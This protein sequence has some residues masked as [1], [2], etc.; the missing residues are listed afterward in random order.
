MTISPYDNL[1][2][3]KQ[4][5]PVEK[6]GPKEV[7]LDTQRTSQPSP[8]EDGTASP[9]K[10]ASAEASSDAITPASAG[11]P[12]AEKSTEAPSAEVAEPAGYV[13]VDLEE[14]AL[15]SDQ[16]DSPAGAAMKHLA[17]TAA[18]NTSSGTTADAAGGIAGIP[19]KGSA[20]GSANGSAA[21]RSAENNTV[22]GSAADSK[23]ETGRSNS[24][25]DTDS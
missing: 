13:E 15:E 21:V 12:N 5:R 3:G 16:P 20:P 2:T 8:P 24:A 6:N 7:S 25:S 10:A 14:L 17:K 11:N 4:D 23:A 1:P 9:A 19:A 22:K 18:G